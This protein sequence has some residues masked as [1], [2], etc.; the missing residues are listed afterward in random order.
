MTQMNL[1]TENKIMD[2]ENRLVVAWGCGGGMDVVLG[3]NRCRLLSLEWISNE[4]LLC[5]TG[6][7]V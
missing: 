4:I 3:A 6:K 1:S 2:L 5:S 7:Y